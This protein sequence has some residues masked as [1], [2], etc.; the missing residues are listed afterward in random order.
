MRT[1]DSTCSMLHIAVSEKERGKAGRNELLSYKLRPEFTSTFM[2]GLTNNTSTTA[3]LSLPRPSGFLTN[4]GESDRGS[5][6]SSMYP[7]R[8][9]VIE[10]SESSSPNCVAA[11]ECNLSPAMRV[12]SGGTHFASYVPVSSIEPFYGVGVSSEG[13]L[14][15]SL[16]LYHSPVSSATVNP[17]RTKQSGTIAEP[18][19]LDPPETSCDQNSFNA[20]E[21]RVKGGSVQLVSPSQLSPFGTTTPRSICKRGESE[22]LEELR[23]PFSDSVIPP[24]A[25][26]NESQQVKITE[27]D[28]EVHIWT[29]RERRKKMRGMFVTLHSMLPEASPKAD[30]S[31][32]VDEA[33]SYIKLLEQKLQKLLNAKAERSKVS[34]RTHNSRVFMTSLSLKNEEFSGMDLLNSKFPSLIAAEAGAFQT[35]CSPNVVL[36]ICGPDAFIN[37]C[38]NL[39]EGLLSKIFSF[40]VEPHNLE[41]VNVQISSGVN[42]KRLFMIHARATEESESGYR[43]LNMI[44]E[45][46]MTF[47]CNDR[48]PS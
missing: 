16:S 31:T 39:R 8:F 42:S 24:S 22:S 33:I 1:S 18:A 45:D 41:I 35:W 2:Q 11:S 6:L 28:H 15:S 30:K 26:S 4:S 43:S 3:I 10:N 48:T 34:D 9:G 13:I 21:C 12:E 25:V 17:A 27:Q 47:L 19:G 14:S 36:N 37:I 32:I 44:I 23:R 46:L 29:E 7:E 20:T 38:A 40:V 5:K